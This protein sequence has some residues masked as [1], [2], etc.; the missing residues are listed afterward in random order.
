MTSF[1][2][3]VCVKINRIDILSIYKQLNVAEESRINLVNV[4][5]VMIGEIQKL[6]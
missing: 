4:P 1:S 3:W 6:R 2:K 5:L